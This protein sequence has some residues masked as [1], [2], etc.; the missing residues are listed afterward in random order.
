MPIKIKGEKYYLT[1]DLVKILPLSV[2]CIRAY[3]IYKARQDQ[4]SKNG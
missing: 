3:G 4:G 2:N 1:S